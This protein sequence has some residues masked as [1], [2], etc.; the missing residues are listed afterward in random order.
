MTDLLPPVL[1]A[2]TVAMLAWGV[3]RVLT[4]L[5]NPEKRKLQ[6]RLTLDNR[7][8]IEP[9]LRPIVQQAEAT[10]LSGMLARLPLMGGLQ[11]GLVQAYPETSLVKFLAIV[12]GA[13]LAALAVATLLSTSATVGVV[14]GA[15]GGAVPLLALAQKRNRRQKLLAGQVPE[16]L[17]FLSRVLKAGHSFT[18]GLQMMGEELPKPLAAE[19]RRAYDQHSLGLPLEDAMRDMAARIDSTDFAFFVTAVL[20]QRQTG[21]DLSEVLTNISGM[22][23]QRIRLQSHVKSKTAEGRFSGYILV[24]FPAFMFVVVAMLNPEYARILTGTPLGQKLLALA[25][26]L[27]MLGLWMIR[28]LTTVKV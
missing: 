13:A 11:R 20:I 26:F 19:F 17:D 14:T 12:A 28:K 21:G 22:I 27:Q 25:L 8:A 2:A 23:R 16:A 18:T 5:V 1:I 24:A 9:V 4:A 10:G 6:Q 3:A 15:L 7:P